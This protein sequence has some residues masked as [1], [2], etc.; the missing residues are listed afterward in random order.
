MS[1][2]SFITL[3]VIVFSGLILILVAV[4]SFVKSKVR[5]GDKAR[6]F[7]NDRKDPLVVP[8]GENLL[9]TLAAHEIYLSSACGGKGTCAACKCKVLEG[10]GDLLPT[11]IGLLSRREQK[12][13]LRLACQCK[14]RQDLKLEIPSEILAIRKYEC[15]V[16]SNRQVATFI[17]EL[18]L[19]TKEPL[20][21]KPGAYIQIDIPSYRL[22]FQDFDVDV[23]YRSDWDKAGLWN[24][25]AQNDEPVFRAYSMANPPTQQPELVFNVRIATPPGG[26][27]DLP[28]GIASSYLFSLKPGDRVTASGPFGE[29]FIK[30]SRREMIYIGGGAG[31]APLRSHLFYLLRTLKTTDR[32]ISYWY[33]ARSLRELFYA[34]EFRALEKEFSNFSFH[35]ALSDPLP[36]DQWSGPAGF[37]HQEIYDAYLKNHEAPEEVEYYM[38]GPPLMTAAV[39]TMLDSLGV[40]PSMIAYDDFGE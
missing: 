32:K 3:S 11:E 30:D 39:L 27:K 33:G 20:D 25:T 2:L 16:K 4:L 21:F 22:R 38:C 29:F 37:I 28:P 24:L 7:I 5:S 13:G 18:V 12:E 1:F 9:S 19:E 17:K 35:V 26:D 14:V 6:I 31:M 40:D 23:K 34:D 15:R 8:S 10:G 36:D